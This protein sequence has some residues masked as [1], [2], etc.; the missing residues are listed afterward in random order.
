LIPRFTPNPETAECD[1]F[2]T[3]RRKTQRPRRHYA[4]PLSKKIAGDQALTRS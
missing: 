1:S 3:R 4:H 2:I